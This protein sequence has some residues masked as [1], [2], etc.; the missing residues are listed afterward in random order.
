VREGE[1][2]GSSHLEKE[3]QS[4]RREMST[5]LSDRVDDGLTVGRHHQTKERAYDGRHVGFRDDH[6]GVLCEE[7]HLLSH[8]VFEG[9][10]GEGAYDGDEKRSVCVQELLEG[11][12]DSD[13]ALAWAEDELRGSEV[14]GTKKQGRERER[15]GYLWDGMYDVH[16]VF[17][18][19]QQL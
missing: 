6:E 11:L 17:W 10:F 3:D 2:G 13:D 15:R 8:V 5:F 9:K 12:H 16:H 18:K 19:Q 14:N 4:L 1:R 7:N